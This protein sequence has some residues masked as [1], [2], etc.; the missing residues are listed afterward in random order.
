M[1]Y[2]DQVEQLSHSAALQ[3]QEPPEDWKEAMIV[4]PGC[5]SLYQQVRYHF[6]MCFDLAMH[7]TIADPKSP[8]HTMLDNMFNFSLIELRFA[9]LKYLNY[10]LELQLI[11]FLMEKQL[12]L[13]ILAQAL[14]RARSHISR[15][16]TV[17]K[18]DQPFKHHSSKELVKYAVKTMRFL[19]SI[20]FDQLK[21]KVDATFWEGLCVQLGFVIHMVNRVLVLSPR[22]LDIDE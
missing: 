9:E 12:E 5:G 6:K 11:G 20:D 3:Y 13:F 15:Q 4:Q 21:E 16:A 8:L 2:E 14:F 17:V 7:L 22:D 1:K 18:G 19:T 10:L